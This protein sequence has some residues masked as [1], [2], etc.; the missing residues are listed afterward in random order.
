MLA[1][2][3]I[4]LPSQGPTDQTCLQCSL[5]CL[6][7]GFP[8]AKTVFSISVPQLWSMVSVYSLMCRRTSLS[9]NPDHLVHVEFVL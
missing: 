8:M 9:L 5:I 1:Q 7:P 4:H 3:C 6:S 2:F